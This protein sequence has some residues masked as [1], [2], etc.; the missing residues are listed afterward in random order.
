MKLATRQLVPDLN[1]DLLGGGKWKLSEQNPA[2]FTL[3]AFY[4]GLHCPKCKLSLSDLN[5]KADDFESLGVSVLALSCDTEERASTTQ[6]DW[7]LDKIQLGYG[8]SIESAREW[9][10]YIST[11]NGL[12]SVGIEEPE[13][14]CEPGLFVVDPAGDLY[15]TAIQ[16]M[17]FA[18][19]MFA[20]VQQAL[21]FV[22]E[23]GYP[24]RGEA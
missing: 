6:S 24:A 20:E 15:M 4:R 19:P 23:K 13:K 9:G 18:R 10:L 22:I 11:S 14:F 8:L 16:S 12:T 7:G 1:V 2:A 3:I 17:P 5:R 21:A